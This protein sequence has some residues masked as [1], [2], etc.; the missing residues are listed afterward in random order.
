MSGN[1]DLP[2]ME[3]PT[4][5]FRTAEEA[6]GDALERLHALPS[7]D[8]W[9][10]ISAQGMGH[11]EESYEFF[12]IRV[13]KNVIDVG[14]PIGDVPSIIRGAGLDPSFVSHAGGRLELHGVNPK[15]AARVLDAIFRI[16]FLLRSFPEDQGDYAVGAEW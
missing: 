10:T 15:E 12:E 11:R 14:A 2:F 8:R 7:W 9:I 13:L 5:A 16:H 3:H 4:G 6:L 1:D